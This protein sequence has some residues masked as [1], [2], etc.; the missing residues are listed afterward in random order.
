VAALL[1]LL[2]LLVCAALSQA[3]WPATAAAA[4]L[5]LVALAAIAAALSGL[6]HWAGGLH[7][8][9][10][11]TAAVSWVHCK[12]AGAK[13]LLL[14]LCQVLQ[15]ITRHVHHPGAGQMMNVV[16]EKTHGA[17]VLSCIQ[18]VNMVP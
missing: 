13:Q 16:G 8:Q 1:L 11:H 10:N 4:V 6:R 14:L 18:G 7:E 5:L 12:Q 9:G 15:V 2:R 17:A 3:Q